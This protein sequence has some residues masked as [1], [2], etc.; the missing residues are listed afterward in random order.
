MFT[1]VDY[2]TLVVPL[3]EPCCQCVTASTLLLTL[4]LLCD[5]QLD[6]DELRDGKVKISSYCSIEELHPMIVAAFDVK[7]REQGSTQE[8]AL[9]KK[10]PVSSPVAVWLALTSSLR[11]A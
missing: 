7:K 8:T 5:M 1:L 4:S 3:F 9:A 10:S 11:S 2:T 6:K